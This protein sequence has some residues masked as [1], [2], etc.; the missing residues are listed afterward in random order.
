MTVHDA[1]EPAELVRARSAEWRTLADGRESVDRRPAPTMRRAVGAFAALS[2]LALGSILLLGQAVSGRAAEEEALRDARAAAGLLAT[3]VVEPALED[4]LLDGDPA[5]IARLDAVVQELV[6]TKGRVR[7]KLWTLDGEIV[8]SDEPRLIGQVFR[9]DADEAQA[10]RG[11][12]TSSELSDLSGPENV[13]ERSQG[14][15]LEVYRHV[16]LPDGTHLL[17]EVYSAYSGLTERRADVLASFA[18]ITIGAVLLLQACQLPLVWSLVRRLRHAQRSRE[19]LLRRAIDASTAERRRLAG[20]VHDN[21]VQGL[22][23]ASFVIAGAVDAVERGGQAKVATELREAARG[24]RESIRGLRAMLVE[25]YPPSVAEA[26]L[27]AALHDLVAPLRTQG[28]EATA[29]ITGTVDVPRAQEALIFRVAQES[30][31]NVAQHSGASTARLTL[32]VEPDA[33]HLEVADDGAG[34]DIDRALGRHDGHFGIQVLRD[35]AA[36]AGAV[37]RIRSGPSQGTTVRLEVPLLHL[38]PRAAA[39]RAEDGTWAQVGSGSSGPRRV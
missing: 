15:L 1:I 10:L 29:E 4:G 16:V 5:A 37:L 38:W 9:L 7:V 23:G 30:L 13:Y 31:R 24:V 36:E 18:P 6:L 28:I 26:G 8:Y 20:N 25:I 39:G 21:V 2:A 27:P 17:F 34:V 12:E 11:N 35:L 19:R 32:R 22:A 3:A 33:I 14:E